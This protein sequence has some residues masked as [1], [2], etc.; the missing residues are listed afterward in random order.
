L[1]DIYTAAYDC[2]SI[3]DPEKKMKQTRHYAQ[4]W[5]DGNLARL[6]KEA[7]LAIMDAGRPEKP[8]LVSPRDVPKRSLGSVEGHAALIHAIA[9]IEFNAINLAWDAVY[10]FRHMPEQY[11][12][13]WV[14]VADEEAYHYGLVCDCLS[15][16]GYHYGD[17]DAHDGLWD[18]AQRTAHD[19]LDRMALVPR[20]MEARGL[21]VTPGISKR[22]KAIGNHDMVRVLDIIFRDEIGHVEVGSRWYR[23]CCKQRKLEP[24]T[25]FQVLLNKYLKGK[26]RGPFSYE[27]RLQ[28]GFDEAELKQLEAM[29]S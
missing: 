5:R 21:D 3:A 24:N 15:T 25:T 23:Y 8:K 12:H 18:M 7:P 27:A 13:D 10:R 4:Q 19:V 1:L 16:L 17:F 6:S 20:V 22:F 28:A 11:Y 26:L 29:S 9:H 14:R 2:L